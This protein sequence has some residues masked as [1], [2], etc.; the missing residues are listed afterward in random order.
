MCSMLIVVQFCVTIYITSITDYN[1]MQ[2]IVLLS[3]I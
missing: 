2:D 1:S 3:Q